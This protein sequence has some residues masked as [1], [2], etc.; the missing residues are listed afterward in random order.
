MQRGRLLGNRKVRR[1]R[2]HFL[3][4]LRGNIF[5]EP[6]LR[7]SEGG[8]I[9]RFFFG[10]VWIPTSVPQYEDIKTR[11]IIWMEIG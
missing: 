1:G 7:L 2:I 11:G 9:H 5:R 8:T 4:E 6:G 3:R 10:C